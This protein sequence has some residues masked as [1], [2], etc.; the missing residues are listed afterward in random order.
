MSIKLKDT[1][2]DLTN[3]ADKDSQ[4]NVIVNKYVTLDTEQNIV[5]DKIFKEGI[6]IQDGKSFNI[7]FNSSCPIN[8][9]SK[10][11]L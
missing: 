5:A 6:A 3:K 11:D 4:G 2:Y 7:S 1:I 9:M 8:I 10:A